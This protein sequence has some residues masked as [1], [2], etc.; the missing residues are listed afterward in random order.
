MSSAHPLEDLPFVCRRD[1]G[2]VDFWNPPLNLPWGEA[3]SRGREYA[4]MLIERSFVYEPAIE[5]VLR[6]IVLRGNAG[7]VEIGLFRCLAEQAQL[8]FNRGAGAI[9]REASP[10]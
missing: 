2:R 5:T 1:D 10:A 9:S 3:N 6:T 4:M 7:G 8:G